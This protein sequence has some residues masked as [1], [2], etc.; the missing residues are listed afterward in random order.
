MGSSC[1]MGRAVTLKKNNN[2]QPF[3]SCVLVPSRNKI[4]KRSVA[5]LSSAIIW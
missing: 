3:L 5:H 1:V 4:D 2:D